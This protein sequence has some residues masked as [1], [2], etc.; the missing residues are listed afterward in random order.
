M[1]NDAVMDC[2]VCNYFLC[3]NC[4]PWSE[5]QLQENVRAESRQRAAAAH[6]EA[7]ARTRS[8]EDE[9]QHK[10]QVKMA[11]TS[12]FKI[13][14]VCGTRTPARSSLPVIVRPSSLRSL[15]LCPSAPEGKH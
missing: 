12:D 13:F 2:R 4:A 14:E 5:E 7:Q 1:L 8:A 3:T 15:P 10:S 9:D 11:S 6:K